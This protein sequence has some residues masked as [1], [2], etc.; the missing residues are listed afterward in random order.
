MSPVT[1]PPALPATATPVASYRTGGRRHRVRTALVLTAAV[2]TALVGATTPAVADDKGGHRDGAFTQV[3]LV[4][5]LP[6]LAQLTD[7]LVKN[8][9]GIDFGPQTPLWVSNQGSNSST[10]Y[11][12]GTPAQPTATKVPLEVTASSPTGLVF[13]PTTKF[14]ITQGGKTAPANFL[15]NENVFPTET[16]ST[17]QISG[18]SNA[19]APPPPTTTVVKASKPGSAY[20]GL[21]LVPA[22]HKR[23]PLLLAADGEGRRIDVYDGKFRP[24]NLGRRAFV[25]PKAVRDKLTPYNV[26]YLDGRVYVAYVPA[27]EGGAHAVS[28]FRPDGRFVKRLVTNGPLQS[29]W[30]MAIAPKHWGG[31]G[32]ALLVGNVDDGTINAFNRHNGRFLGTLEDD[33]GEPLVNLGLWGIKFGN[34]VIG[35]PDDLVFAAGI[36]DEVDNPF[37]EVYEHG[38]IGLIRPAAPK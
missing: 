31:F 37:L 33:K 6:G 4:S 12:G 38:L 17:G 35:T 13:N 2:S 18:W 19:S 25:D 23:G 9:W 21:A 27:E 22:L 7:P 11:R 28:A 16:T 5:D 36:G 15:F 20:L 3:N 34:G 24:V 30:G 10:L 8:P 1:Q 14:V 32:G 29:P 26:T